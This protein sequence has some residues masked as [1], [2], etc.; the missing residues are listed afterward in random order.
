[1]KRIYSFIVAGLL[2]CGVVSAHARPE[3]C[4]PKVGAT[5]S[6][7][8]KEVRIWFD[9]EVE[10]GKSWVAVFGPDGKEVDKKDSHV[11]GKERRVMVV[12]LGEG[13]GVGKYRV[14]WQAMSV[15]G[16]RT[17]DEFGFEVRG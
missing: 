3:K 11:E 10:A 13:L 14:K 12:S 4:E 16:H 6:K 5:V 7:A 2:S 9:E 8:P 1:M 15:D 17:H